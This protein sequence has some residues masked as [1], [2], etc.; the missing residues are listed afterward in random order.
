M[1][2]LSSAI[3]IEGKI[4]HR[5]TSDRIKET[6]TGYLADLAVLQF[7][8]DFSHKTEDLRTLFGLHSFAQSIIGEFHFS[9]NITATTIW[10]VYHAMD[11]YIIKGGKLF[12]R[13]YL[14]TGKTSDRP[15]DLE[16]ERIPMTVFADLFYAHQVKDP[17]VALFGKDQARI[18]ELSREKG[19]IHL[20]RIHQLDLKN[21]Q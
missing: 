11:H 18:Y 8:K 15:T 9:P 7:K 5:S 10:A 17:I 4:T 21:S 14:E 13:I 19:I 20:D 3:V 6:L 2:F 12:E 16:K 1:E